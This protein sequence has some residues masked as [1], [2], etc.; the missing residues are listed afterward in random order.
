VQ[1]AVPWPAGQPRPR[2]PALMHRLHV[3]EVEAAALAAL[4]AA[5]R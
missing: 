3:A 4:A 1:V 2:D 5:S